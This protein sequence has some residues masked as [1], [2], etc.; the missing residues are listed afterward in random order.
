MSITKNIVTDYAADDTGATSVTPKFYV[1]LKAD[2][3]GQDCNLTIPDNGVGHR[4]YKFLSTGGAPWA[5][6]HTSLNVTATGA[7]LTTEV[8]LGPNNLTPHSGIDD[9]AGISA[10]IQSVSAGATSITLTTASASAGHISRAVIGRWMMIS[11]FPIQGVFQGAYG[12]PP[13]N[14]FNDHVLITNI[15]GDTISFT[16]ALQNSYS[17]AWPEFTRGDRTFEID[18]AGPATAYFMHADWGAPISYTG[19]TYTNADLINCQGRDMTFT[20]ITCD[21]FPVYPSLNQTFRLYTSTLAVQVEADKNNDLVDIQGGTHQQWW[22]QSSSTRLFTM[23]GVTITGALNGTPRNAVIDNCSMVGLNIGPTSYGRG[24]TF[25][26]RN[27]SVITGTIGGGITE[28][29]PTGSGGMHTCITS[30]ASG[31]I[32]IPM[33]VGDIAT[34]TFV[35]DASGRNVNFWLGNNGPIGSFRVLSVTADSWPA[36]DNQTSTTNVTMAD[37][38]KSLAVS[39][40]IFSSGDVGKCILIPNSINGGGTM[41]TFITG[42]T[43][44]QHVTVYNACSLSGGISAS[45]RNLQ[46]GTCNVYIQTDQP[47]GLP[48]STLY[49]SSG[50][51]I[52]TA[53]ARSVT[54]ESSCSGSAHV[55]DLRQTAAQ[56]RPLWSY[57]KR[58]YDG[59]T[60]ATGATAV[61]M[62]GNITSIKVNVTTPYTGASSLNMGFSQFDNMPV[63]VAGAYT[64]YGPRFD[65]KAPGERTIM[66]GSTV[67]KQTND[68][69]LDISAAMFIGTTY[70]AS[71]SRDISA[72]SSS[73]W[74]S[75]TIEIITDQ[76]IA[77]DVASGSARVRLRVR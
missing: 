41:A 4:T 67:N 56:G 29:G 16:P 27:N 74:P 33:S 30:M 42:F 73:L 48:T 37:G 43:D 45:S 72:E 11:G 14:Q 76:G 38:S 31:L 20:G 28:T 6:G 10:R 46:W 35:P 62:V 17:S 64:T 49:N 24:E 65:L 21:N 77:A 44:A 47:G 57:T 63:V 59:S 75:F 9:A 70:Q 22:W 68:F 50:L 51:K 18:G 53:P 71:M 39:S 23:S 5:T 32:T 61:K 2:M 19:G 58:T 8:V 54:F 66:V 25:T 12:F 55:L 1:N 52:Q 40:S 26:I 13:N 3:A 60:G 34:R 15:V 36:A 69:N 7:S